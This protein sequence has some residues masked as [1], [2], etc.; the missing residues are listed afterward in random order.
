MHAIALLKQSNTLS[1]LTKYHTQG[2][3]DMPT[4]MST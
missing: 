1:T 3:V 2:F 4:I